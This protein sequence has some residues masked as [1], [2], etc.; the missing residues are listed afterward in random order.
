MT[1]RKRQIDD[2]ETKESDV[3]DKTIVTVSIADYGSDTIDIKVGADHV[4]R[5]SKTMLLHVP[6]FKRFLDERWAGHDYMMPDDDPCDFEIVMRILHHQPELLPKTMTIGRLYN[7]ALFTDKYLLSKLVTPHVRTQRWIKSHWTTDQNQLQHWSQW[8]W[9]LHV[10]DEPKKLDQMYR[11]L[12]C[13]MFLRQ[14]AWHMR[15]PRGPPYLV[16]RI[17]YGA[18]H[19]QL[20]GQSASTLQNRKR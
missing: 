12:A 6:W 7:L 15:D 9:I 19:G 20:C 17:Q 5:V 1:K 10:F 8:P 13:H 16:S 2:Q 3:Q 11:L 14:G 18:T 4:F